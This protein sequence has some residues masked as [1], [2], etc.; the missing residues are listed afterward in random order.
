MPL[1]AL[2]G[3]GRVP[4]RPARPFMRVLVGILILVCSHSAAA[5]APAARLHEDTT[6]R[7]HIV[8]GWG[9]HA[10]AP[11]QLSAAIGVL[12]GEDWQTDGR[13]HSRNVAVFA[14]PGLAGGRASIAYVDQGYGNFGSGF[15]IAATAL[16]TWNDPWIARE[17]VTYVGGE[18]LLWPVVFV[19]PR[20]GVFHSVTGPSGSRKWIFTVDFG[21]GL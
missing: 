16:R 6:P 21:V 5:Q 14:E 3:A 7:T 9:V 15:G 19:G 10:G 11:Q 12:L 2:S 4:P 1:A 8:P 18:A 20:I 13:D 17:N